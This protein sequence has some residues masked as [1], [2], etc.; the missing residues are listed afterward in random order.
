[1]S[2]TIYVTTS[3]NDSTGNGSVENP[4]LTISK[5]FSVALNTSTIIVNDSGTYTVVEGGANQVTT[6]SGKL[7]TGLTFKAGD[8]FT[9]IFDGGGSA[10]YALKCW[11]GYFFTRII[12]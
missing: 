2:S 11:N 6:A 3:G 1:M 4:Y 8:G 10:T 9:P 5:A 12:S 7:K